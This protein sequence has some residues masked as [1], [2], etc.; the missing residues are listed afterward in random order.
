MEIT[1]RT[2]EQLNISELYEVLELRSAVFVVEQD[3]V[4]QDLDGKDRI[5]Y[6]IVG[7]HDQK[8]IAYARAFKAGSYFKNASFGRVVV[9]EAYRGK[10]YAKNLIKHTL[11][12]MDSW[13]G[14]AIEISAQTYLKGFYEDLGFST[15]GDEY[16]EDGIPHIRMIR[17]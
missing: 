9:H 8:V 16:L 7:K 17:R 4:Y 15:E 11:A 1:I 6:H 13:E 14:E 2:F 3:C 12:E 5:A 10:G